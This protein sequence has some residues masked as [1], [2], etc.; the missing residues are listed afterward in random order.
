MKR[1]CTIAFN[2]GGSQFF[3][4]D[5]QVDLMIVAGLV[6]DALERNTIAFEIEAQLV[7]FPMANIRSTSI[8]P[9]PEKL[10]ASVIKGVSAG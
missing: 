3:E 9:A 5:Q 1:T 6:N 2:D 10:P 7:V 4:F 8:N